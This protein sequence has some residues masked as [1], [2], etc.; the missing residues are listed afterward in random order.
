MLG[1]RGLMTRRRRRL[2][3]CALVTVCV[4][5]LLFAS[6]GMNI[7]LPRPMDPSAMSSGATTTSAVMEP[8]CSSCEGGMC[9]MMPGQACSCPIC[10]LMSHHRTEANASAQ[11]HDSSSMKWCV[12][13]MP[14]STTVQWLM[15]M[16]QLGWDVP[17]TAHVHPSS[18]STLIRPMRNVSAAAL[19][20]LSVDPP[21][22]RLSA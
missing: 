18:R 16:T 15:M 17:P 14:C 2:A 4:P 10:S 1:R 12:S 9:M 13:A 5:A 8:T 21:P 22:P 3:R 19:S 11:S 20:R 6:M 7:M